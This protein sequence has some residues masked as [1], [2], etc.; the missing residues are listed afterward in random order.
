MSVNFEAKTM[1]DSNEGIVL[2]AVQTRIQSL[3]LPEINLTDNVVIRENAWDSDLT[4]PYIIISPFPEATPWQ[5]GTNEADH[6]TFAVLVTIVLANTRDT[7]TKGMG[8]Q[9]Y[10]RERLR[11]KFQNHST[12]TWTITLLSGCFFVRSFVES[13]DKFIEAAK[14][15]QRDAQYYVIRVQIKETRE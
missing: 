12:A 3:T 4:P 6:T 13:G 11:R 14:R 9:L 1:A 5:E 8:L 15:L 2:T 10:W 7:T